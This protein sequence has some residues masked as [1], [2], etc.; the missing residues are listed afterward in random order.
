M[1]HL[2]SRSFLPKRSALRQMLLCLALLTGLL[3]GCNRNSRAEQAANQPPTPTPAISASASITGTQIALPIVSATRQEAAPTPTPPLTLLPTERLAA[4]QTLRRFGDYAAA[5]AEF[6]ALLNDGPS[7]ELRPQALFELARAQRLDGFNSETLATLDELD[8]VLINDALDPN[9]VDDLALRSA[10]LRALALTDLGEFDAAV[11]QYNALLRDAPWMA[12]EL[13]GQIADVRRTVANWAGAAESLRAAVDAETRT[14][15]RVQG[16]E[17]LAEVY[18]AADS[19]AAAA[20]AYDEIL[21]IAQNP[22]YR[23]TILYR[24]GNAYDAAAD[25]ATAIARWRAATEA[26]PD[27]NAAYLS[28]VA[29][30]EREAEFDLFQ[31]GYI[32]ILA[33]A[34]FPAISAFEAYVEEVGPNGPRADEAL[35]FSGQAHLAANSYAEAIDIFDRVIEEYPNCTC[36]GQAWVDKGRALGAA[37][38]AEA[39]QTLFRDFAERYSQNPAGADALWQS[40]LLALNADA[41]GIGEAEAAV[42]WLLMVEQ[43]PASPLAPRAL[44]SLGVGAFERGLTSITVEMYGRLRVEYPDYN[45]FFVRYWLGRA[46]EA[47]GE[48]EAA[49]AEWASLVEEVPDIYYGLLAERALDSLAT[50]DPIGSTGGDMLYDIA[51]GPPSTLAGDDGSQPFAEAWLRSW[52]AQSPTGTQTGLVSDA[53]TG[54]VTETDSVTTT[55]AE[56][57]NAA[58]GPSANAAELPSDLSALPPEIASD[59]ALRT[60]RVLLDVDERGAALARLEPLYTENV[61]N[62]AVLYPLTLEFEQ[63][64]TYRL[65]LI[66]ARMLVERSPA[67]LVEDAPVFLQRLIYPRRFAELIEREATAQDIDPFVYYSLIRQESL[68]EEGAQSVAAA[69]GLAQIIP[70]TGDWIAQQVGY[71]NYRNELVYRP[72]INVRFGA[73]YLNWV[74]GYLDGNM[75]SALVGYNAGPGNA[76]AWRDLSGADD[77]LYAEVLTFGE[78]R[79]YIRNITTNV[80]HYRR[81]YGE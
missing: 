3:L 72:H 47:E 76:D 39:A 20:A 59:S 66:A 50:G 73:Y 46:L 79:L 77:T 75:I 17:A 32:D 18:L 44:Y 41:D 1:S 27:D 57:A 15:P 49:R 56:S 51:P 26:A 65:S 33:G 54:S 74:R 58:D 45:T 16:L 8:N 55:A 69:Q 23:A 60:A 31:R 5:R 53:A 64:G 14:L 11:S 29:L 62:P 70:D 10:Y 28:L 37:G 22:D 36:F 42:D 63:L 24:A 80:Y 78:P 38:D 34:W 67:T 52:L 68:F 9:R 43:Y 2:L 30:V 40:G 13:H 61:A 21:D 48:S 7:A 71:P 6:E 35:H 25:E 12:A 4:G 81:L 19:P